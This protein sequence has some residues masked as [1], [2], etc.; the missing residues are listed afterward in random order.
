MSI[1]TVNTHAAVGT[2]VD[3]ASGVVVCYELAMQ[4]LW[5][6]SC[7]TTFMHGIGIPNMWDASL[8]SQD[9]GDSLEPWL[10]EGR[11]PVRVVS[12]AETTR[13]FL[14]TPPHSLVSGQQHYGGSRGT[15]C[16]HVRPRLCTPARPAHC[17][18]HLARHN[19][20][21]LRGQRQCCLR[22]PCA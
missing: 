22:R 21:T 10:G 14:C 6:L 18:F 20:C 17:R 13:L 12:T 8:Y 1:Q 11:L 16:H 3:F 4:V 5:R 19:V 15:Q 7:I 9:R 2:Q